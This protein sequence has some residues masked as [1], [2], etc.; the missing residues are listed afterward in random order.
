[1]TGQSEE[2]EI[3][4]AFTLTNRDTSLLLGWDILGSA[5]QLNLALSLIDVRMMLQIFVDP[6]FNYLF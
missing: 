6:S 5:L 1:M 4:G 3:N 2:A